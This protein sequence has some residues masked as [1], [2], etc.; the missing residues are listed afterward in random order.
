MGSSFSAGTKK[1]YDCPSDNYTSIFG[2]PATFLVVP[3]ARTTKIS[4]A[5][6]DS[7]GTSEKSV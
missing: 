7:P 3:G 5:D 6:D 1:I 2:C 4:N